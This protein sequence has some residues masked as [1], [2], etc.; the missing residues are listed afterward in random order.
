MGQW[1]FCMA[2]ICWTLGQWMPPD[3]MVH[4]ALNHGKTSIK[5][6]AHRSYRMWS[7]PTADIS[8]SDWTSVRD[9]GSLWQIGNFKRQVI[10][11]KGNNTSNWAEW[12]DTE[13]ISRFS[14]S[15]I[16]FTKHS[17]SKTKDKQRSAAMLKSAGVTELDLDKMRGTSSAEG[18]NHHVMKP[19]TSVLPPNYWTRQTK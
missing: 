18:L 8:G 14:N 16:S 12:T 6:I 10:C 11:W 19:V 3:I 1:I 9:M 4:K 17:S 5:W 15:K 13:D 2:C 7:G